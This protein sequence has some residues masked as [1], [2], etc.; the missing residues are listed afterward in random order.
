MGFLL[1]K[2]LQNQRDFENIRQDC[3][4]E[5][6][7]LLAEPTQSKEYSELEYLKPEKSITTK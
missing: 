1:R 7:L 3:I 4:I 5:N 6:N 2:I